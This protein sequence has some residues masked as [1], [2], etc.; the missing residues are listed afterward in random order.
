MFIQTIFNPPELNVFERFQTEYITVDWFKS[1]LATEEISLRDKKHIHMICEMEDLDTPVKTKSRYTRWLDKLRDGKLKGISHHAWDD[2]IHYICKGEDKETLPFVLLQ[3]NITDK[4][5]E[6]AHQ[7]HWEK[8][9][10]AEHRRKNDAVSLTIH[11]MKAYLQSAESE[12]DWN[13]FSKIATKQ[14]LKNAK[15]YDSSINFNNFGPN[16]IR[17]TQQSTTIFDQKIF[18]FYRNKIP[19]LE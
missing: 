8:E 3:Y 5:I 4:D 10:K 2:Q 17:I 15:D 6:E 14:Y 9:V 12:P 1:I 18:M 13:K 11:D 16:L 7:L 19:N